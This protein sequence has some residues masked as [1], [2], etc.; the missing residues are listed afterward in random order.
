MP[1][2]KRKESGKMVRNTGPPTGP[3]R[4]AVPGR[5]PWGQMSS[6]ICVDSPCCVTGNSY[7]EDQRPSDS[8]IQGAGL[9]ESRCGLASLHAHQ[10]QIK[11]QNFATVKALWRV[12]GNDVSV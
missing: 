5:K 9:H 4:T 12:H 7:W 8:Q 10:T 2:V 1:L 3:V 11:I 6:Q